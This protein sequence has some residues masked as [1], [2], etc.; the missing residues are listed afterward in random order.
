ME[1]SWETA[2]TLTYSG[3]SA[4]ESGCFG[5][6]VGGGWGRVTFLCIPCMLGIF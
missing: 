4:L 6:R 5:G 2:L 1:P 3:Q